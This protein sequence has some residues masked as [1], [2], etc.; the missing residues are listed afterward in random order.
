MTRAEI[1]EK[2]LGVTLPRDYVAFLER[3]GCYEGEGGEVYGYDDEIIDVDQL[4]CVIGATRLLWQD[5]PEL[6][7]TYVS[8][9]FT[10][11]ENEQVILNTITGEIYMITDEGKVKIAHS[12]HQ[13]FDSEIL[14]NVGTSD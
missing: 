6:A 4:P 2:A 8:V 3:Y 5:Y 10:G 7:K 9:H 12:F 14:A 1:V 13:W 11:A